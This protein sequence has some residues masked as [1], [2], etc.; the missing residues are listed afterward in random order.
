[1]EITGNAIVKSDS[2][3]VVS[4]QAPSVS[5]EVDAV[6]ADSDSSNNLNQ[7]QEIQ[8]Q[9]QD[10]N[11]TRKD[12][13][14]MVDTLKE[15]TET[16]QTKMDFSISEETNR[17]VVK[18]IDQDTEKIIK[19]FPPEEILELQEKMQDLTGFLFSTDA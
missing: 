18:V 8:D 15:M 3:T 16:L 17:L 19:Q 6:N 2:S 12:L 9:G 4:N 7:A 5:T 10:Q 14:D 1:M 11:I 13:E